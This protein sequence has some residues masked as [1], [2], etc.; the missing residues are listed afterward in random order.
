MILC[1][2]CAEILRSYG[3]TN[4]KMFC[5]LS[6]AVISATARQTIS[7]YLDI[8]K[9]LHLPV[10]MR[11][12]LTDASNESSTSFRNKV[13]LQMVTAWFVPNMDD[14]PHCCTPL[15]CRNRS[16][17]RLPRPC[18]LVFVALVVDRRDIHSAVAVLDS[19]SGMNSTG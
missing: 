16:D 6:L 4:H 5:P 13:V 9:C 10:A 2:S 3:C 14:S 8:G 12:C 18:N 17:Q 7:T 1:G 15:T 19:E 11:H